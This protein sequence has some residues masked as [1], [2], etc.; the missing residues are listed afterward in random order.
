[1]LVLD[2]SVALAWCFRDEQS[3]AV[4]KLRM[5]SRVMARSFHPYGDLKSQ[6]ACKR[7]SGAAVSNAPCAISFWTNSPHTR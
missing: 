3:P 6:T 4:I 7:Q 1:M 5:T 2:S